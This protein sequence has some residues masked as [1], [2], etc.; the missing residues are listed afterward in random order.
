[1]VA[2][3]Q[4][5][6]AWQVV[7]ADE[8]TEKCCV[9]DFAHQRV[10]RI[11][12]HGFFRRETVFLENV[13]LSLRGDK[14]ILEVLDGP[15][16]DGRA[17]SSTL[18]L[19]GAKFEP[20]P[21]SE[22]R[23]RADPNFRTEPD[24]L[25]YDHAFKIISSGGEE[26]TIVTK[27]STDLEV[28][29]RVL[30]R[31]VRLLG[32]SQAIQE[33]KR[34]H[35]AI[36]KTRTALSA[37]DSLKQSGKTLNAWQQEQ[38]DQESELKEKLSR[39]MA[40]VDP[41]PELEGVVKR[42]DCLRQAQLHARDAVKL[43]EWWRQSMD[44][45]SLA[46]QTDKGLAAFR[47]VLQ[48]VSQM[49]KLADTDRFSSTKWERS[50]LDKQHELLRQI[51]MVEKHVR[52]ERAVREIA[53]TV[54]LRAALW[55][56]CECLGAC[57]HYPQ[58]ADREIQEL[59]ARYL[60]ASGLHDV[61]VIGHDIVD[62]KLREAV[63]G[64]VGDHQIGV[65][66]H[67]LQAGDLLREELDTITENVARA[68]DRDVRAHIEGCRP[69]VDA[70]PPSTDRLDELQEQAGDEADAQADAVHQK[71]QLQS[72]MDRYDESHP[73]YPSKMELQNAEK[74]LTDARRKLRK[75]T[76]LVD[77]EMQRLIDAGSDHW[78]E[79]LN[80]APSIKDFKR[81]DF[82]RTKNLSFDSYENVKALT[83]RGRNDVST[84]TLDGRE[85]VLKAC[86]RSGH[87]S[88]HFNHGYIRSQFVC[89]P[90]WPKPA[91]TTSELVVPHQSRRLQKKSGSFTA[92]ATQI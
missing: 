74:A 12:H 8:P 17:A 55:G 82:L 27:S 24:D 36:R 23:R 31:K 21:S 69:H 22:D 2:F 4:L 85:V 28:W 54:S 11:G 47:D 89:L 76:K 40:S 80:S 25:Q 35:E 73:R 64:L 10:E 7:G 37:V 44:H 19:H 18:E 29:V 88:A 65:Y 57:N 68:R 5:C 53:P 67:A 87:L 79:V 3:R 14:L 61:A 15:S 77:A 70:R 16:A 60:E 58:L 92:C 33:S 66:A 32:E 56:H 41:E 13:A 63:T 59:R 26:H 84:A 50:V 45:T 49:K 46:S 9:K 6:R 81:M 91:D 71:N 52:A 72:R 86:A 42:H 83:G 90:V 43:V 1:M 75:T 51:E 34:L 38:V 78:P 20:V 62:Q 30:Q 48:Q 39:L